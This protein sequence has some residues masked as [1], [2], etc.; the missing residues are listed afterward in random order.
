M[1][2]LLPLKKWIGTNSYLLPICS[3]LLLIPAFPRFEQGYLA[4]FALLPLLFFCINNPPR[5]AA[6]GGFLFGLPISLYLNFYLIT[7]LY[8]YLSFPLAIFSVVAL[9]TLISLYSAL[10]AAGV[11]CIRESCRPFT[12]TLAIPSLWVVMEYMRSLGFMGYNVGYLGYTQWRY[13]WLLNT[14]ATYGYWGLPFVMVAFQCFPLLAWSGQLSG[15]RLAAAAAVW[16]VLFGGGILLPFSFDR[17]QAPRIVWTALIQGNSSPEEILSATGKDRVL[18]KYLD[19]TRRA[20]A[21]QP[22]INL[23]VWPE[24]VVD[25]EGPNVFHKPE[26]IDLAR[27]LQTNL[28]YGAR[29]FNDS[30][31]FNSAVA[32]PAGG[33]SISLY[34]KYRLVPFVEYS[35][36]EKL[37]NSIVDL[38]IKVGRYTVGEK[39][40]TVFNLADT[41]VAGVIC[42]ESYFGDYTR[43]FAR[44]G[45]RHLFVLT[46]DA[47]F[48]NSTSLEH[49][50]QVA[51]IRAA[52][53]GIG[54]TQVANSGITISFDYRGREILRLPKLTEEFAIMPLNTGGRCT[55]YRRFG[56]FL[57]AFC[58]LFLAG[59]IVASFAR[60]IKPRTGL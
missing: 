13:P 15:R 55:L 6:A 29:I 11:S 19:L 30:K 33:D 47:W 53:N 49:H 25:L 50:A 22:G 48:E 28:L 37:L 52:E 12:L 17:E 32:L 8:N 18:S 4:W 20:A 16:L 9:I 14:A 51:A 23:V 39:K 3:G 36:A 26:I 38:D 58:G 27:E 2:G 7:V 24:T 31:F 44:D 57:P 41:P 1:A 40:T 56:D 43:R 5:K 34:H 45:A 10:F 54:V 46:N 42:F 35:P 21:E 60:R 59:L